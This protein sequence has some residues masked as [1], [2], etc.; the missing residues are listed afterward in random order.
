MGFYKDLSELREKWG[1]DHT[2]KSRMEEA[3]REKLFA[4]WK[5]AVTRSFNWV[6]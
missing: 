2:W 4:T 6:E 5:K 3:E 1:V